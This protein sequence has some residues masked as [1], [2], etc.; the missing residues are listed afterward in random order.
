MQIMSLGAAALALWPHVQF[1][2]LVCIFHRTRF[3]GR[4]GL[5]TV[6]FRE[7]LGERLSTDRSALQHILCA[8]EVWHRSLLLL[9]DHILEFYFINILSLQGVFVCVLGRGEIRTNYF[10]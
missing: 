2:K 8:C 1:I 3:L 4:F 6:S 7:L 10:L 9:Q 5:N